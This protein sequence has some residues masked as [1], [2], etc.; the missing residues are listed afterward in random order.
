MNPWMY[1][2]CTWFLSISG[3]TASGP[4]N[5]KHVLISEGILNPLDPNWFL[6]FDLVS[7]AF[8]ENEMVFV[9]LRD[10]IGRN[11]ARSTSFLK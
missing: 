9:Q 1:I 5:S 7:V 3:S 6:F 11:L 8:Y 10:I 2:G 4:I